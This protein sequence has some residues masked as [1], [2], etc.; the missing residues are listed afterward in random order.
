MATLCAPLDVHNSSPE[1]AQQESSDLGAVLAR[2]PG[3]SVRREGGLGSDARFSLNGL[4]D[5]QVRFF[6]DGVPLEFTAYALGIANV[7]V[8]RVELIEIY[9]G[10]VPVRFGADAIGGAVNLVSARAE[11]R[12]GASA[13]LQLGAYET[14]RLTLAGSYYH[15]RT[16]LFARSSLFLDHARNDYPVD[17][18]VPNEVGRLEPARVHRFHD[19]YDA[20]G[21]E[22]EVGALR[23]PW[24]RRIALNLFAS[25]AEKDLQSNANMTTP[26][27]EATTSERTLGAI[28]RSEH[29]LSP[30]LGLE[31]AVGYS[32]RRNHFLDVTECI[33]DWF[34][35]CV[36]QRAA[37]G[38]LGRSSDALQWTHAAYGRFHF[39]WLPSAAHTVRLS[40]APTWVT[41]T[42]EERRLMPGQRDPLEAEREIWSLVNGLEY[43]LRLLDDALENVLFA[44]Q[45]LQRQNSD[46]LLPSG[47]AVSRDQAVHRIG[48]GDGVRYRFTEA[49]YGKLS[50]EW[51]TRL[52]SA[53]ELFGDGR[54]V[55]SNLQL[56]PETSHNFNLTLAAALPGGAA[57]AF[58]G[59]VTGFARSVGDLILILG[60]DAFQTYENL[61]SAR[62]V[63]VEANATWTS[64]GEWLVLEGSGT[65]QEFVN[66]SSS[67]LFAD[68]AGDRIPN[69]PWLFAYGSARLQRRSALAP[70]DELAF[71]ARSSW[72][73]AF[74]LSWESIGSNATKPR[75]DDQ[76]VFDLVLSYLVGEQPQLSSSIELQNVGNAKIIDVYGLQRPGR[77]AYAKITVGY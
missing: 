34:G 77:S 8:N 67:G 19:R 24:A 22:L 59:E 52:P 72:T 16:G 56:Q 70:S 31:T 32:Y 36:G 10:V 29:T 9:S 62:S 63:G 13:S 25:N 21:A 37:P 33:W 6:F 73:H 66:T 30:V 47:M 12:S 39:S 41:R 15:A 20:R 60:S 54:T 68:Y 57:G 44:K 3:V 28:F 27:G 23:Q 75:V 14:R 48:W 5:D 76:L 26:Y 1:Q 35:R 11:P 4:T 40:L 2:T 69:R 53:D 42:G 74:Y 46:E 58:R 17:V 61:F 43:R 18:Q 49:V 65:Y 64:P 55:L 45:Y 51:A 71:T 50:Y 38:E 7:P